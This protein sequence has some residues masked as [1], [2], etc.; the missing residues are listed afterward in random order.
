MTAAFFP[1]QGAL[2][3]LGEL[4]AGA[5]FE[6]M[7]IAIADSRSQCRSEASSHRQPPSTQSMSSRPR[8]VQDVLDQQ[9]RQLAAFT[10]RKQADVTDL[11]SEIAQIHSQ[12]TDSS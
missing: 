4:Q 11:R 2:E 3:M 10:V 6:P 12:V 7:S 8:R 1:W 9:Q 5:C